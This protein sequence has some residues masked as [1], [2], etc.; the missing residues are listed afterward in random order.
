MKKYCFLLFFAVFTVIAAWAVPEYKIADIDTTYSEYTL[1]KLEAING[2]PTGFYPI[3]IKEKKNLYPSFKL[4]D[5]VALVNLPEMMGNFK[6]VTDKT[7]SLE[8]QVDNL[9]NAVENKIDEETDG[10]LPAWLFIILIVFI[11]IW[12]F[13]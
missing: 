2:T 6:D 10:K 11:L 8:E 3:E 5:T 9:V 4:G 7:K 12:V 1:Y 13:S